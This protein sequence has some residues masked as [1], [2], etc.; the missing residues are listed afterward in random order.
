MVANVTLAGIS[1][2][3]AHKPQGPAGPVVFTGTAT[4]HA[5]SNGIDITYVH[6]F[7]NESSVE[8]ATANG[9]ARLRYELD[10]LS[11]S[12]QGFRFAP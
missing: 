10:E 4:F 6:K 2:T 3:R 8:I 12:A 11:A 7:S 5:K 1:I 9:V